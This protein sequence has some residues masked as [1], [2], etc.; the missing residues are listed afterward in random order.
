MNTAMLA[1]SEET[2][3]RRGGPVRRP[4]HNSAGSDE[5]GPPRR[6]AVPGFLPLILHPT[7]RIIPIAKVNSQANS[8]LRR[9]R[10]P[11]MARVGK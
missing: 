5:N 4:G 3:G 1:R 11:F 10:T 2:C 7:L 8:S 6:V 9:P